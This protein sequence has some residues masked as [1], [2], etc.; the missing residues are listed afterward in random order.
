MSRAG[1]PSHARDGLPVSLAKHRRPA[2]G[3]ALPPLPDGERERLRRLLDSLREEAHRVKADLCPLTEEA[4]WGAADYYLAESR[5]HARMADE[6]GALAEYDVRA[7]VVYHQKRAAE[8]ETAR[9]H[10]VA[11]AEWH[12]DHGPRCQTCGHQVP[13]AA[14]YDCWPARPTIYAERT[15]PCALCAKVGAP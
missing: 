14:R 5:I 1:D 3:A 15:Y 2:A 11:F 10:S 12:R 8:T 13:C 6:F 9:Q 4:C 7:E